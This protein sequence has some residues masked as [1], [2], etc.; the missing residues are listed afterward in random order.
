MLSQSDVNQCIATAAAD[1]KRMSYEEL[2]RFAESNRMLN[3][4][5]SREVLVGGHTVYVNTMICK[6]GHIQK[7]ISVELS[8]SA[9]GEIVPVDTPFLYFERYKSGRFYPSPREEAREAALAKALPYTLVGIVAIGLMGLV[10]Y[11][12]LRDG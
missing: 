6:L 3:D 7:R 5:K 9:E 12:L 11:F 2:E 10:W 1:L 8:L 4:W